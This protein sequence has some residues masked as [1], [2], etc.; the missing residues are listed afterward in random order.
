VQAR[1]EIPQWSFAF[2]WFVDALAMGITRSDIDKKR[3]IAAVGHA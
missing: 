3:G 2:E 1:L